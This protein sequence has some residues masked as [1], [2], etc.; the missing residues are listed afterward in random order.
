MFA[1]AS[2]LFAI[3]C[4]LKSTPSHCLPLNL[5]YSPLHLLCFPLYLQFATPSATF[6]TPSALFSH[7]IFS[8]P[9]HLQCLPLQLQIATPSAVF[10]T[11]S[12]LLAIPSAVFVTPY[13][14]FSTPSALF[15]DQSGIFATPSALLAI[16]LHCLSRYLHCLPVCLLY[17]PSSKAEIINFIPQDNERK[18]IR[19]IAFIY[20]ETTPS[21][22]LCLFR[23]ERR[24]LEGVNT[25]EA[26]LS[27]TVLPTAP[28]PTPM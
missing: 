23:W 21:Y 7:S 9:L 6:A 14:P 26:S 20:R 17:Y 8:L 10:A 25:F 16:Y 5:L 24:A 12:A 15:A 28:T 22:P 3:S 4:E 11:P 19:M 18:W 13:A 1:T 27:L 2:E